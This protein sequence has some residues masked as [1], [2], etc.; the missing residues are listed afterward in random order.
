MLTKRLIINAIAP[1]GTNHFG[2]RSLR[3]VAILIPVLWILCGCFWSSAAEKPAFYLDGSFHELIGTNHHNS[4]IFTVAAFGSN[5][6]IDVT[7][8]NGY[9]EI[10]GTDGKDSFLYNP[11]T[12]GEQSVGSTNGQAFISYGRFP[13]NAQFFAQVLWAIYTQDSLLLTN[14][15]KMR[16]PFYG[17]YAPQDIHPRVETT[18]AI[19]QLPTSI[20]WYAPNHI[21]RGTNRYA[22]QL[23][24]NGWLMAEVSV[25]DT[26]SIGDLVL[27]TEIVYTTY[28]MEFIDSAS[29]FGE[30]LKYKQPYEVS[31]IATTKFSV[32]NARGN[33][34]FPTYVPMILDKTARVNDQRMKIGWAQVNSGKWWAVR[35]LYPEEHRFKHARLVVLMILICIVVFPIILLRKAGIIGKE[36]K[37]TQ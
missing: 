9:R 11:Y 34:R 17:D 1:H 23:Y 21:L 5:A 2:F 25:T 28:Q 24:P 7:F 15:S 18:K 31:P 32:N 26:R 19:P 16:C 14:L 22:L 29:S 4:G 6:L 27:P 30:L 13:T 37:T 12:A 3:G 33:E 36:R 35:E 8:E 10:V 20:R